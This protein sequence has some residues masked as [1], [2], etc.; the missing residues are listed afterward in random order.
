MVF[1]VA[2][3]KVTVGDALTG[4]TKV[5]RNTV[6]AAEELIRHDV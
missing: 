5:V 3:L 4:R 1:R 2:K 6:H